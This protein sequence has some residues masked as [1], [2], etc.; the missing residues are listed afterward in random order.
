M[1]PIAVSADK[2]FHRAHVKPARRHGRVRNLAWPLV[3]AGVF[4]AVCALL[5]LRGRAMVTSL[6]FLQIDRIVVDGNARLSSGAVLATLRGLRGENILW[7]DLSA[8]RDRLAASP[9]VRDASLRRSL[10][11][12]IEVSVVE[13]QPLGIGRL[14]GRLFLIDERGSVIDEYGPQYAE[15]DLP[16]IDGL[17][18]SQGAESP[19]DPGRGELAARIIHALRAKPAL[20][21]RLSQLDVSNPHNA[22]VI[23]SGDPALI[24]VGE[25][26]FVSRLESYL[27]LSAALRE[28]VADIDYVDLRFENRIYVRPRG[29]TRKP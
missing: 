17:A 2:R 6:P 26:G 3:K 8:W 11:S 25:D 28:R 21:R 5:A 12:T 7:A 4:L 19:A 23:L 14:D 29:R 15:F 24:Y 13:R 18:G 16:I 27:G 20:A 9:W 22:A 1:S 10:P